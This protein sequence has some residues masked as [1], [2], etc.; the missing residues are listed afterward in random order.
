VTTPGRAALERFLGTES[1]DAGCS[2]TM[3]L[4]DAYVEA[5]VRGEDPETSMPGVAA[6]LRTCTPCIEDF[7]GLLATVRQYPSTED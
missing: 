3:E 4:L 5:V 7:D 1:A 6:H 2:V